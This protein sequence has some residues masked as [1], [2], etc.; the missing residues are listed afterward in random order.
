[1]FKVYGVAFGAGD[2]ASTFKLPNC[3]GRVF[4]GA[5]D[6]GYIEAGLPGIWGGLALGA[7]GAYFAGNSGAFYQLTGV[8]SRNQYQAETGPNTV[9]FNAA[10][11]SPIYGASNTVQP[12]SIKVRVYTRYK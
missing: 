11:C 5:V 7:S 4:W 6:K 1:M 8:S 10:Y 12:P 2:G 9:N 3:I